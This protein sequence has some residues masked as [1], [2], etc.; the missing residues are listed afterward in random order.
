M[1]GVKRKVSAWLA[2]LAI[3]VQMVVGPV[4]HPMPE[5]LG[6]DGCDHATEAVTRWA[7][8]NHEDAPA[9]ANHCPDGS[10]HGH[11]GRLAHAGC[12]CP[13]AHTPALAMAGMLAEAPALPTEV[14]TDLKGPAYAAPLFD[15]L[16]PPN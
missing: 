2:G 16:R 1:R 7:G 8:D 11:A 15:F 10:Q 6:P 13:C 9:G 12:V 3:I 5:G 4:A 14:L